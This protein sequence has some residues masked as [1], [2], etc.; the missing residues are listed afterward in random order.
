MCVCLVCRF[1]LVSLHPPPNPHPH[2]PQTAGMFHCHS[3]SDANGRVQNLMSQAKTLIDL[4]EHQEAIRPLKKVLDTK[5]ATVGAGHVDVQYLCASIGLCYSDIGKYTE[6]ISY[7][8]RVI[9]VVDVSADEVEHCFVVLAWKGKGGAKAHAKDW[10]S[11]L[12]CLEKAL[13]ACQKLKVDGQHNHL[14]SDMYFDKAN[15][16]CAQGKYAEGIQ[17]YTQSE[18]VHPR[19]TDCDCPFHGPDTHF[20][21]SLAHAHLH[22]KN[23]IGLTAALKNAWAQAQHDHVPNLDEVRHTCASMFVRL[24]GVY[25]EALGLFQM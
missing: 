1:S 24:F 20:Y 22:M 10:D 8:D 25:P 23:A 3:I 19:S 14:L 15:V 11:C 21:L 4:G 9:D 13:E 18:A 5:L 7:Y 16:L 2:R 12:E 6:A 17:A